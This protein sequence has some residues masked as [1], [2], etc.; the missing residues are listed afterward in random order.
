MAV[1]SELD[2]VSHAAALKEIQQAFQDGWIKPQALR[3]GKIAR[4]LATTLDPGEAEAIALGT[5]LCVGTNWSR[6]SL[7]L[8]WGRSFQKLHL[9][10]P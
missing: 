1:Q 6:A 8:V 5:I 3:E 2:Q 7:Q 9:K 10:G 4:L